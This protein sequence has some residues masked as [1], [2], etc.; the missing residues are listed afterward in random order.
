MRLFTTDGSKPKTKN[1]MGVAW[2]PNG[3][4]CAKGQYEQSRTE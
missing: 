1:G 4:G 3:K 2:V